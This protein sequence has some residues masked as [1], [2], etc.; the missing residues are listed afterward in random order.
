MDFY[1]LY[2]N[3]CNLNTLVDK[4]PQGKD[5][6]KELLEL[7][8]QIS[9]KKYRVAVIGEFKRGKSSL[10]N[11]LLGTEIL[12]TDILPTTAVIN[13]VI[14]DTEQK[15]DIRYKNG[16]KEISTVESLAE[17][18]TK[19]DKEKE[20]FAETIKEIVVHYPSVLGQN[21]FEII[22]TPGL[23]D[24]EKMTETTFEVFDKI[25][26]AIVVI[27]ATSPLSISEQNLICSLIEQ[28]DI[29]H[30]TFVI[31]FIDRV[32]DEIE[33]QDRLVDIIKKRL[34]NDTY[35]NFASKHS[36]ELLLKKA[37]RIL[38]QPD[39]FAV[40]AKQAMQGFISGNNS[41][42]EKSRFKHFKLQLVA[43][44]TANQE[45]DILLKAKRIG[46]ETSAKYNS[47]HIDTLN[48][49]NAKLSEEINKL[50]LATHYKNT[51]QASLIQWLQA[52][53]SFIEQKA[54]FSDESNRNKVAEAPIEF[55]NIYIKHLSAIR[56]ETFTPDSIPN[57]IDSATYEC[58]ELA[59]RYTLPYR[60]CL[61]KGIANVKESL[62]DLCRK[63][64]IDFSR[65]SNIDSAPQ[66]IPA[67]SVN[68]LAIKKQISNPESECIN[69]IKEFIAKAFA[70]YEKA[71]V[72]Y[73][74]SCRATL[75]REHI[76]TLRNNERN[77]REYESNIRS[78]Q[79]L[80][81]QEESCYPGKQAEV[82][83]ITRN[84]LN[85]L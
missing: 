54:V 77:I 85:T 48:E 15:I 36:D 21:N 25:D 37:Q 13:R 76:L 42:I 18:A 53:D 73:L 60:E 82:D 40:S 29:Y 23:N 2:H 11:C 12:P 72:D 16:E 32:S 81:E 26:T 38:C 74:D 1:S 71:L 17:Y 84:I 47:W 4:Y 68:T 69:V 65:I 75:F 27:S 44:L 50:N 5:T 79:A 78:L 33:E 45:K 49:L 64:E 51:S 31:T 67:F 19:L 70:D 34:Q 62:T 41:L 59:N 80:L 46:K 30:L 14:Y 52:A 9:T 8:E 7:T 58:C 35:N 6:H 24:N 66:P 57:A 63:V 39:V 22:D 3:M 10:V 28:K 20:K 55:K 56:K 83:D 43:L 61:T